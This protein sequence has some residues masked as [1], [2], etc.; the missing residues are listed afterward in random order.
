MSR[1]L[2]F[3][4]TAAVAMDLAGMMPAAGQGPPREQAP[5]RPGQLV[6][7]PDDPAVRA[8]AERQKERL[9]LERELY[10]LRARHFG[11][12]RRT[13][14]RQAGIVALRQFTDPIVYPSLLRIFAREREDVR[15]A[16]LDH[17]ADQS[18]AQADAMLAWAAVSDREEWFRAQ[19]AERLARRAQATGT[20]SAGVIRTIRDGLLNGTEDQI[21][22][23]ARLAQTLGLVEAIPWL[24]QAQVGGGQAA[25]VGGDGERSRAYIVIG[26]QEAFV[27][28]LQPVVGDNA[29]AFDPTL[30]VVTEGTVLRVIDA[31]VVT[32]RTIVHEALVDISTRA[33]GR[34]TR[35]LGWDQDAWWRWY[36][37]EFLPALA[38]RP[39]PP[40]PE[41][42]NSP[43]GGGRR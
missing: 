26:R 12:I 41:A 3:A 1:P 28:D 7:D 16:V 38:A 40:G 31:V 35:H 5:L 20:V 19:A 34:S 9:R 6:A 23:A 2:V 32:Y 30:G 8:Y 37:G 17:L 43:P 15:R 39:W 21:A 13:D 33:W 27:A 10:R 42:L 18:N 24:I 25:G 11:A 22:A 4:L 14:I 36:R 29:V